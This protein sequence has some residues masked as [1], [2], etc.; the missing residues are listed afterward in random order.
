M[1][2]TVTLENGT[3]QVVSDL[4]QLTE[5]IIAIEW[6]INNTKTE[7]ITSDPIRDVTLRYNNNPRII[8]DS[9]YYQNTVLYKYVN[10]R[11]L[12]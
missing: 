11:K 12:L 9:E 10:P 6:T 2:Y 4:S 8:H 1:E 3:T 7:I 5:P